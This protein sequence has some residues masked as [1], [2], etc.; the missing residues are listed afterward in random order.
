M[1]NLEWKYSEEM[2]KLPMQLILCEI[3]HSS[4]LIR[5]QCTA[6][7]THTTTVL[8]IISHKTNAKV[9]LVRFRS[10]VVQQGQKNL[11]LE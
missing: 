9:L 7:A 11:R 3:D 5:N 8:S 1:E 10:E 4:T 6:K 2:K